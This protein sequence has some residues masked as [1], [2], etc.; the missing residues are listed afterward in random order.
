MCEIDGMASEDYIPL[1]NIESNFSGENSIDESRE[2][3]SGWVVPVPTFEQQVC[4]I[5]IL[6]CNLSNSW[7]IYDKKAN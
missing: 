6:L 2:G 7:L 1:D 3:S 4:K 5:V